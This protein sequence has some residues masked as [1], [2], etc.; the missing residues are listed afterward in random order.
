MQ[1][2]AHVVVVVNA[3][4]AQKRLRQTVVAQIVNAAK[5]AKIANVASKISANAVQETAI[6]LVVNAAQT[7][8]IAQR[9]QKPV[10]VANS[11]AHVFAANEGAITQK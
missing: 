10:E 11:D 5:Q 4:A 7:I 3:N 8:L 1:I 9:S 6:V 2:Y